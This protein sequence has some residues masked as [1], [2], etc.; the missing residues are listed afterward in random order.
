MEEGLVILLS[1]DPGDTVGVA[2][3]DTS[4]GQEALI[5]N[6]KTDRKGFEYWLRNTR[7][8][9]GHVVIEDFRLDHRAGRQQGSKVGASLSIGAV[10][11]YC[12]QRG[13][14]LTKQEN[15]ILRIT[16]LHAGVAL[17]KGHIPDDVSAYLHGFRWLLERG[18][19]HPIEQVG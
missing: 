5:E 4:K 18:V 6:W 16:A 12:D 13:I 15:R 14:E 8:D 11:F 1:V 9:I 7:Y 3:W 17:P 2:V 19:L 10:E